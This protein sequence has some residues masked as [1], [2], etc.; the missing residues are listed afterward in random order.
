M[1]GWTIW[2]GLSYQ[3]K[4]RLYNSEL[5]YRLNLVIAIEDCSRE[6]RFMD[7][8]VLLL[9]ESSYGSSLWLAGSFSKENSNA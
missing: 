4:R 2:R 1:E 7:W 6:K 3:S 9:L 8:V 5:D